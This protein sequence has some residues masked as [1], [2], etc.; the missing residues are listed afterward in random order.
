MPLSAGEDIG[1]SLGLASS[2]SST[3]LV[4]IA[5]RLARGDRRSPGRGSRGSF[6][7]RRLEEIVEVGPRDISIKGNRA[8]CNIEER[9]RGAPAK[10]S[11]VWHHNKGEFSRIGLR[12]NA[13]LFP[14]PGRGGEA[15]ELWERSS[16]LTIATELW[17]PT[18][19]VAAGWTSRPILGVR[20]WNSLRLRDADEHAR[21]REKALTLW[22]NCTLGILLYVT[23]ANRPYPGR[24]SAPLEVLRKIPALDV[25]ALTAG[26]LK[27]AGEAW[28]S[29]A[30]RDL[31]PLSRLA[32]DPARAALDETLLSRVLGLP[33]ATVERCADI[34]AK[35]GAEPMMLLPE[36]DVAYDGDDLEGLAPG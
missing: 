14:K 17:F 9:H 18:Q 6:P 34:R 16:R 26:Q 2:L 1:E 3:E 5:Y 8:P 36:M 30:G 27:A 29:L 33:D 23:R 15:D 22:L 32:D 24:V 31:L 19:A 20:S 21:L 11:A 7:L 4:Q 28:D 10:W 25:S 13:T 12:P 35:L